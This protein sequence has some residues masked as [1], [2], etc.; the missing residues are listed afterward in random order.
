MDRVLVMRRGL[1]RGPML[2]LAIAAG[3]CRKDAPAGAPP[4][5]AP[6][7]VLI[8]TVRPSTVPVKYEFVGQTEASK[9]VEIRARVQGVLLK[10]NFE[11]G[12]LVEKGQVLYEIDPRT[13]EAELEV[14]K[15]SAERA[16]VQLANADRQVARLAELARQQAA[17]QKELDDWETNQEQARADLRLSEARVAL[18]ELSLGYT[19]VMSPLN[20]KVG[21]TD[22]D[23]GALVDDGANSLLTTVFQV[24]PMYVVF[25]IPEREWLGWKHDVETGQIQLVGSTTRVEI[26]LLD[27]TVYP[28]D[29][30]M[31]FFDATV[32]P[33]TGTATARG[34]FENRTLPPKPGARAP[35]EA[36]KP[37]QF[38]RVRV[39]GWERPNA[40]TVP[41]RAIIQTPTGPQVLV[42]GEDNKATIRPI[43]TG[44]WYGTEWVVTGGLRAGDRVIVEG[45][46]KAVPG[47]P[48]KVLGE[49]A[50]SS[51]AP[52]ASRDGPAGSS[53]KAPLK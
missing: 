31:D 33:Q 25:S 50:S 18:A 4:P 46:A 19:K 17:S 8:R 51:T 34:V 9:T 11:E 5:P 29:G 14:A 38:V 47:A 6:A 43:A 15:A 36:L 39:L 24:D 30:R 10:R 23:V 12:S 7:N 1:W 13:Y 48:V 37:G 53:D 44:S 45:R 49:Y 21:R 16:R 20:G 26:I 41:Q 52:P 32:N 28:T 27:G 42:V 2:A 22:K 40:L 3:G 35:E